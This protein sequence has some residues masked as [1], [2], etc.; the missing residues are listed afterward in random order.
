MQA[1]PLDRV[2]AGH[3]LEIECWHPPEDVV[4]PPIVM[5]HEGLG[6]VALWKDFPRR[7]A[8][9]TRHVVIA[10]SRYG[11]GRSERLAAPREV[12]YMHHEGER[13]LPA[14]LESLGLLRPILLGH[15]DGASIALIFA[16]MHPAAVTA[17]VLLA[18]H[19]FV[20]DLTVASIAGARAVFET[21]D[22][23]AKLARYHDDPRGTF[24]GWNDIWLDPRFRSWNIESYLDA[25]DVPILLVQ[26]RD[27]EY[28]TAVQLEAIAS[29]TD[30]R[31]VLLDHCG[32]SPHRDQASAT[33]DAIANF[34]SYLDAREAE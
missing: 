16:G 13:A 4:E 12:D 15:S 29:R 21:S 6:S 3:R 7:I 26:G 2:I 31:I 10:Y 34:V 1:V 20:E 19:V 30:A 25:I 27:D 23:Q 14:L 11:H 24:R 18:P 32:H 17:L 33:L 8:E 9:R 5:L 28:G 22:L